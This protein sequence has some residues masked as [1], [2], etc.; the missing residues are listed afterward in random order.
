MGDLTLN[1]YVG[2]SLHIL[3]GGSVV[4]PGTVVIL[5]VDTVAN[6][7]SE[8]ITLSDETVIAIDGNASPTLDIR[9]GVEPF[10]VD[11]SDGF[12]QIGTADFPGGGEFFTTPTSA[13]ILIGSVIIEPP[14]GQ[15]LITNQY[16]PNNSLAPADILITGEGISRQDASFP[17]MGIDA[18]GFGG[19]GSSV[20]LDSRGSILLFEDASIDSSSEIDVSGNIKLLAVEDIL[21]NPSAAISAFS[22]GNQGGDIKLT[23]G[24]EIRLGIFAGILTS[25]GGD[26]DLQANLMSMGNIA[27]VS[28]P[29]NN[30]NDGGDIR[31]SI[32]E[33]ITIDGGNIGT[34]AGDF[35]PT[36]EIQELG[37]SGNIIIETRELEVIGFATPVGELVPGG[38]LTGGDITSDVLGNSNAGDIEITASKVK[39]SNGA[40]IRA[41]T[42]GTGDTGNITIKASDSVEVT[43]IILESN[44]PSEIATTVNSGA[45]GN[46]K[47]LLV[48]TNRLIVSEGAQIQAGAFG[49]GQGGNINVN[50]T[51]SVEIF[52]T[53][54]DENPTGF[55]AGPEGENATGRGGVIN[56]ETI[57]L[58]LLGEDSQISN[59][60]DSGANGDAG[61]TSLEVERLIVGDGARI[62]NGTLSTTGKGGTLTINALESVDLFGTEGTEGGEE[63]V[64]LF[65][66]TLGFAEAGSIILNTSRL[67]IRDGASITASTL[68][69]EETATS[70]NI[71][72][73][74]SESIEVIG[75]STSGR[76]SSS[77][78]SEPGR[79][80][81][82]SN[83]SSLLTGG[84]IT[85][86]TKQLTVE[87]T[88]E[89]STQTFGNGDSGNLSINASEFIQLTDSSLRTRTRGSGNAGNLDITTGR[90]T[91]MG[92]T[93]VTAST[94]GGQGKGGNLSVNA[95]ETVELSGTGGL[96]TLS[97]FGGDAGNIEIE[98]KQLIVR[99]GAGVNTSSIGS[100][101]AGNLEVLASDSVQVS[102]GRFT[103]GSEANDLLGVDV[104]E[105]TEEIFISSSITTESA[106]LPENPAGDLL[107]KT[108]Q[109]IIQDGAFV[110]TRT[111]GSNPGGNLD[112]IASESVEV[113]GTSTSGDF[114]SLSAQTIDAGDAG[115][116]TIQ[117]GELIVT[118]QGQI[119]SDTSSTG[120]AGAIEV[121]A[122][123]LFLSENGLIN[124]SSLGEGNA[125][126]ISLNIIDIFKAENSDINT[127]SFQSSGGQIEIQAKDISLG[128]D[129]D[130]RTDINSGEGGGGNITLTADSIIAFDDSDIFAFAQDGKGGNITLD[131]PAFFAENFTLNSL[132]SNPDTLENNNRADV[133]ATGAVSGAVDIP[134]VSFIQNSLTEL[135]DN[136]INTNEL[137]A[138]SC[139]AP[140][141]NRQQGKFIITGGDSLPVRPGHGSISDFATGEVRNVARKSN[142][143]SWQRGEPIVEPQG[144]YRLTNGKLVLSRECN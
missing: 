139:V 50:A 144:V 13:D 74:A 73:N 6:T 16:R 90:L 106:S 97:S 30:I 24:N 132:T 107:I 118:N 135:P 60:V 21:L 83:P 17:V 29:V 65:I 1:N 98:T 19:D 69:F 3:A 136:S 20:I 110:T 48:E 131:T 117:T 18:R 63:P 38:F 58:S 108:G 28:S 143:S 76:L 116:I 85:I 78:A 87:D 86:F 46:G 140:V 7:I 113:N 102:G 44:D 70:G 130:I 96:T 4:I 101:K 114:S 99:D 26:I 45:S 104:F 93:E 36:A 5:D 54:A 31:L 68:G 126:N 79:V 128:G 62:S 43:G 10:L 103:K 15:V 138:N 64:G 34:L 75:K 127:S 91:I 124:T 39:L 23:S 59:E 53:V 8:N 42:F 137:V 22:D 120:N 129:S 95:S 55:F 32:F 141:G 111:L 40:Q 88:A 89:I 115:N 133:N 125:G 142:N 33:K 77:I 112:I 71:T 12:E 66:A 81:N 49:I 84:N 47:D 94:D 82:F 56:I 27:Q 119:N 72:I 134:D 100:G 2:S 61:N 105:P 80:F 121:K 41:S 52:D 109:L 14:D 35:E 122:N 67:S 11:I 37:D 51:Q 9:A 92:D 57:D 25:N 123:N